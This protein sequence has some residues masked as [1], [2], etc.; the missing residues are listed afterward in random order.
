MGT[1]ARETSMGN[2]CEKQPVGVLSSTLLFAMPL[3]VICGRNLKWFG[4]VGQRTPGLL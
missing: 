3:E 4:V 1:T 2:W